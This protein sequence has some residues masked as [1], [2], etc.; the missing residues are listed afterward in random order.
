MNENLIV[1]LWN[2]IKDS[3]DQKKLSG[4]AENFVDLLA[5]YGISDSVLDA[6]LGSDDYLDDAISYYLEKEGDSEAEEEYE[7][8]EDDEEE[9]Y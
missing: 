8:Y 5:D 3:T 9:D 7:D 2:L 4:T 1:D 6:C